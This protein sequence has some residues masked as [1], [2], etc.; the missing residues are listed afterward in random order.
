MSNKKII[1][2]KILVLGACAVGKTSLV[3]QYTTGLFS[4]EYLS[5]IGINIKH[6]NIETDEYQL[7]LLIWDIADVV[8]H[9]NIPPSYLMGTDGLVLVYDI[10]R[11]DSIQRIYSEYEGFIAKS[12]GLPKIVIGNKLDLLDDPSELEKNK[13]LNDMTT[14]YTSAKNNKNVDEAFGKIINIVLE[15]TL[16]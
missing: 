7:N 8:T 5:T 10:T 4:E 11:S 16:I 13:E 15:K 6:K 14:I 2:K 3:T 1:R 9:Q 12:P